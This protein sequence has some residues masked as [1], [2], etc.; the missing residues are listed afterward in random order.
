MRNR[1]KMSVF[2][3]FA[4]L[5]S[6]ASVFVAAEPV[7]A[8]SSEETREVIIEP[9]AYRLPWQVF[10]HFSE[11]R[12][13]IAGEEY[14]PWRKMEITDVEGQPLKLGDLEEGDIVDVHYYTGGTRTETYPY[15]P[16]DRVVFRIHR[17]VVF[18]GEKEK[19]DKNG[20]RD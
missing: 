16:D 15:S 8:S 17:K 12:I 6:S 14:L 2:F 3:L 10:E 5:L 18:E 4:F 9:E 13:H 7:R 19:S 1:F 11:N 20:K